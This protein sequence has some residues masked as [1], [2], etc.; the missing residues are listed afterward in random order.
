MVG[1]TARRPKDQ[2]LAADACARLRGDFLCEGGPV[3][4]GGVI[5]GNDGVGM[6]TD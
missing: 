4:L 5:P 1:G 3:G 2:T 6:D